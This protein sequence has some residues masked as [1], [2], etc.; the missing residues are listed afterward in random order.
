MPVLTPRLSIDLTHCGQVQ[1]SGGW[2]RQDDGTY[3]FQPADE[4]RIFSLSSRFQYT[5]SPIVSLS[6]IPSYRSTTREGNLNGV[7]TPQRDNRNLTFQGNANLNLPIGR[8]GTLSGSVGR[9][10]YADRSR[11]FPSG[12]PTP[13]PLSELDYWTG[14]LQFSWKP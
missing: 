1:P 4:S 5:P 2:T 13:S 8:R 12:V 3:V 14:S 7:T 6:I 11:E 10:Y 9:Q